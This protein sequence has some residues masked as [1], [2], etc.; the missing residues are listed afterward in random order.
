MK[1]TVDLCLMWANCPAA[2]PCAVCGTPFESE[3][4]PCIALRV[5]DWPHV[6]DTCAAQD[7]QGTALLAVRERFNES[8]AADA[9]PLDNI[10]RP[11]AGTDTDPDPMPDAVPPQGPKP[12]DPF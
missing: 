4:G 7:N 9:R 8:L 12:G 3:P 2:A 6:C 11:L 1:K 5:H 10:G